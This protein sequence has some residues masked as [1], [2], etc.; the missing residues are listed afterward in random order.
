MNL[1]LLEV[2]VTTPSNQMDMDQDIKFINQ[3]NKNFNPEERHK[4]I[5]PEFPPVPKGYLAPLTL[6]LISVQGLV[7]G[8]KVEGVETSAKPL[9]KDHELLYSSKEALGPSKERGPSE[10]LDSHLLQR[11][12]PKDKGLIEK[13]K[14]FFRGPE[15]R[16][17][18]KERQQLSGSSSNLHNQDSTSKIVKKR[19]EGPK[20][21]SEGQ[22]KGKVQVEQTLPTELQN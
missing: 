8:S 5:I 4:W 15:E 21:K 14:N 6:L 16:V 1:L 10:G 7:Y 20:E 11:K 9:D 22:E 17:G 18:P 3:K 19:K 13:P 12:S 2:E